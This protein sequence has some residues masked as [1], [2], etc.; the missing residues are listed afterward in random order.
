VDVA[1]YAASNPTFPQ[2]S[3]ADQFFDED[4]FESYRA[5]GR[6]TGAAAGPEIEKALRAVLPPKAFLP[7]KPEGDRAAGATA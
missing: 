5:L 3:T 2:Q 7:P 1:R 4:Q 6:L